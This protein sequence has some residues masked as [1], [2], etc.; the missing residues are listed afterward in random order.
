MEHIYTARDSIAK[1]KQIAEHEAAL[2]HVHSLPTDGL[3]GNNLVAR[4][5]TNPSYTMIQP[6]AVRR[7]GIVNNADFNRMKGVR[8]GHRSGLTIR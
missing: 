4:P 7:N 5:V 3:V 2:L 6:D 8:F 1:R